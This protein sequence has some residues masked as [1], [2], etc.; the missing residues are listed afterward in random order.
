MTHEH[1]SDEM[2]PNHYFGDYDFLSKL[3]LPGKG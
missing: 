3:P 1:M 2:K